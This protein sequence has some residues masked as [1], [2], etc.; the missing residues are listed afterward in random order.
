MSDYYKLD[1]NMNP[2][3]CQTWEEFHAW[4]TSLPQEKRTPIGYRVCKD[5]QSGI[6]VSTVFL[7]LDHSFDGGV[8][9]LW[10]TMVFGVRDKDGDDLEIQTRYI[11]HWDAVDGHREMC[12]KYLPIET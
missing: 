10:E 8:P 11:S 12:E 5:E 9:V 6:L 4:R 2:I 7:G 3:R 1:E